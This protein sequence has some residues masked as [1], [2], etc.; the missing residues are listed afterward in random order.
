MAL[1]VDYTHVDYNSMNRSRLANA[2]DHGVDA[3]IVIMGNSGLSLLVTVVS[4]S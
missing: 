4:F 3:K 1:E 2:N